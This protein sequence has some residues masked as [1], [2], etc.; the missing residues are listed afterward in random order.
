MEKVKRFSCCI[1]GK[2]CEGY[3]NNPYPIKAEGE[4]C[5]DCNWLVIS[6]RI[7]MIYTSSNKDKKGGK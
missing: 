4:C 1:C 2:K 6:K 5:N 7:E 3:G